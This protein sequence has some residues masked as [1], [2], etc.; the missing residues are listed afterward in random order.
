MLQCKR[1]HWTSCDGSLGQRHEVIRDVGPS[2]DRIAPIVEADQLRQQ[3][4]ALAVPV[5]FD[6]VD[7]ES[8]AD[9][10]R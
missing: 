5:T 6:A 2:D 4:G 10:R 3:L 1:Q 8:H 7:R 9:I